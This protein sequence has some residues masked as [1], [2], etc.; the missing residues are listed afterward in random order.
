MENEKMTL[1]F[2]KRTGE[3]KGYVTGVGS[4]DYYGDDKEDY[5]IIFDYTV[6]DLDDYVLNS[7]N[8]FV[9]RDGEIKL[10]ENIDLEKYL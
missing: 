6:V 3:I 2:S 10:K 9:I 8:Q 1:F 4:M 7:I 5:S